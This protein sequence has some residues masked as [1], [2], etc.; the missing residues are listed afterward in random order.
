[1]ARELNLDDGLFVMVNFDTYLPLVTPVEDLPSPASRDCVVL[2]SRPESL[3]E[4]IL[5]KIARQN[6]KILSCRKIVPQPRTLGIVDSLSEFVAPPRGGRNS[7][8]CALATYMQV[9]PPARSEFS[10]V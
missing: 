1:M 7:I 8:L 6:Q 2:R 5:S 10:L 4:T 9:Q 3:V